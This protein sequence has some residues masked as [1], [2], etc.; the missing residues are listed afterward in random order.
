MI[1]YGNDD[2]ND[3][4]DNGKDTIPYHVVIVELIVD[5]RTITLAPSIWM[6]SGVGRTVRSIAPS[7]WIAAIW[8]QMGQTWSIVFKFL[9]SSLT[10]DAD[11]DC[12]TISAADAA[13]DTPAT[14]S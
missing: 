5:N 12:T 6:S 14:A 13:A 1:E 4:N 8:I 10:P 3:D 2:N 7:P 11:A 9:V